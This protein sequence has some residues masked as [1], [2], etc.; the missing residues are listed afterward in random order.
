M[1]CCECCCCASDDFAGAGQKVT[2]RMRLTKPGCT[3]G[4][5]YQRMTTADPIQRAYIHFCD[6]EKLDPHDLWDF[7]KNT[8]E[9]LDSFV[10]QVESE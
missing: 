1:G 6:L 2:G 8:K 4:D 3:M 10:H 5:L 9:A 7:S